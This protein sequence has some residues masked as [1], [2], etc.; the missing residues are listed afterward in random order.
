M[1][2]GTKISLKS[3]KQY[4]YIIFS[5]GRKIR[6]S[7]EENTEFSN[8]LKIERYNGRLIEQESQNKKDVS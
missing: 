1:T 8:R 3:G 2:Y 7:P 6:L 4:G 5:T